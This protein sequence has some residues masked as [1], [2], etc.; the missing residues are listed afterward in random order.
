MLTEKGRVMRKAKKKKA[1]E[2]IKTTNTNIKLFLLDFRDNHSDII[3]DEENEKFNLIDEHFN[4]LNIIFS[5][6]LESD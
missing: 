1:I 3:T 6:V 2:G 5:Q 4:N